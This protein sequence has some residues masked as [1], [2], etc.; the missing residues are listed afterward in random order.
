MAE[1]H[2]PFETPVVD[3]LAIRVVVD[4]FYERFPPKMEHDSVGIE[5]A[6]RLPGRQMTSLAGEWGLSLHLSSSRKGARAEYLLDFGYTPEIITR[7][8]DILGMDAK[9]IDGLILSHGHRDH[10]GGLDGFVKNFRTRMKD[11]INLYVG[12]ETVFREKWIGGKNVEPLPWAQ[13]TAPP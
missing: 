1:A 12:G 3:S 10:F 7:N 8:F 4:S 2:T 11:D 13:S 5:Q 9:K 6:G